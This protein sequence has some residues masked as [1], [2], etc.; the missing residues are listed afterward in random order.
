MHDAELTAAQARRLRKAF[1]D[2]VGVK[3]LSRRFAL[4]Q[5]KVKRVLDNKVFP[6]ATYTPPQP[7]R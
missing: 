2:G 3:M 6:D 4:S 1:K 5:G 7:R